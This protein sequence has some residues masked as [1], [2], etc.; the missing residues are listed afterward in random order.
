MEPLALIQRGGFVMYPILLCSLA[1]LAVFFERLWTLRRQRLI[2]DGFTKA[3]Q[4]KVREGNIREAL[5]LCDSNAHL[6]MARIAKAALTHHDEG[7]EMIRFIVAEVGGQEATRLEKYQRVLGTVA[8]L[9]PLLGLLGT[10]SGMITA[11]NVISSSSVGDPSLLAG[12]ISE[13]LITTFAGLS[14]AIPTVIM[15]RFVQSRA[16]GLSLELDK[17][18]V[19]LTEMLMRGFTASPAVKDPAE[20]EA[21]VRLRFVPATSGPAPRTTG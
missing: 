3:V 1:A 12:G 16:A 14:V 21:A 19:V 18:A 8:Y 4:E 7:P 9:T 10:V 6:P 11:F 15:D 17:E 20:P 5:A 2:P 13:A